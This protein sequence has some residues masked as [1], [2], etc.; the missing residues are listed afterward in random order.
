LSKQTESATLVG[1]VKPSSAFR[2]SISG[3]AYWSLAIGVPVALL[4]VW[5]AANSLQWL[6]PAFFPGPGRVLRAASAMFADQDL[7]GDILASTARIGVAFAAAAI[8]GVPLGLWM[9]SFKTAEAAIEPT[10]DFLRYVPVPALLPL[11][12]LWS[13]IDET[14]KFLV[15]FFGT[16]FQLTLLIKD[17]ADHVPA[18]YFDLARTLGA[19]TSGLIRDVLIP[20]LMPR[21]YDRLRVTLGWC[22]T[23]LVIAELIAV[24][25]GIGHVLKEAQRFNAADQMFVCFIVLGAI[26]LG[27]DLLLK[28]GYG[29]LFPHAPKPG[30]AGGGP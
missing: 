21:I 1:R 18:E 13:G 3:R 7:L 14:P 15:L 10:V 2:R 11:F 9:S 19:R 29:R 4:L 16:V 24:Q 22:W 27:T 8:V 30:V 17:D 25:K 12:V 6:P 28:L 20:H 5:A 26:G 23:Y